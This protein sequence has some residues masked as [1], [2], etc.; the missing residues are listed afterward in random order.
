MVRPA[1]GCVPTHIFFKDDTHVVCWKR[2]GWCM[3]RVLVNL[4]EV[5]D[6]YPSG[7]FPKWLKFKVFS[8]NHHLSNEKCRLGSNRHVVGVLP[9]GSS[10]LVEPC[11]KDHILLFERKF[12][13]H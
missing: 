2:H 12:M 8:Y 7:L 10:V 4:L 1:R 13:I 5:Q 6:P 11:Y 3:C 9:N